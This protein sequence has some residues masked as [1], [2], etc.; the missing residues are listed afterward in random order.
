MKN[1]GILGSCVSRD[2]FEIGHNHDCKIVHYTA[3]TSL[4]TIFSEP[5]VDT[6]FVNEMK[7]DFQRRMVLSDIEKKF[8]L[9]IKES[10]VDFFLIDLIDERFSI[11]ETAPGK[12]IT[13]SAELSSIL[14]KKKNKYKLIRSGSKEF[15]EEWLSGWHQM[16]DLLDSIN[17]LQKTVVNRVYLQSQTNAGVKFN[18]GLVDKMNDFLFWAYSIQ[19]RSLQNFQFIDYG[20][21]LKCPDEHKWGIAPFH[22]D[23]S[24][25]THA[26]DQL[27]SKGFL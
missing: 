11:L 22:Y 27:K 20:N 4:G 24:S 26:L 25:K 10:T 3:R 14:S 18:K 23:D 12:T 7:S 17:L 6:F 5:Q 9:G 8:P 21:K 19:E 1:I 16:I 15:R 13:L 2:I